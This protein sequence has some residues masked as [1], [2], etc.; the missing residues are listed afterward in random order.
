[1]LRKTL[2]MTALVAA[3]AFGP[4]AAGAET[5]ADALVSAYRNSNLLEQ[6]RAALRAADEDVAQA[7]A[8]LR[9]VLQWTASYDYLNSDATGAISQ[10]ASTSLG[11][12]MTLFDFGRNKINVSMKKETVLAT[13][14]GLRSVE[15][16]VLLSAIQ[17]YSD[18]KSASEQVAINQNSARVLNEELKAS[19]DRFE[20][21]E[22][23]KTDVSLAQ[24]QLASARA[25]LAAAQGNLRSA[26]EAYKAAT[27]HYPSNLAAFPKRPS[28]PG[29]LDAAR[30]IALRTHPSIKQLQHT[31][32]VYDLGVDYARANRLPKITGSLGL[33]QQEQGVQTQSAG[34]ELNQT[35]YS[36]GALLSAQ[37]QAVANDQSA[38]AQ[39]SQA[40]VTVSQNVANAWAAIDIAKAQISAYDQQITAAR[41]AYQGVKEEALLGARTTLDVLSAEQDLLDAQAGRID[42][43][44]TLQVA[45]YQLLSAMG[46]LTVENLKLGIPTYDPAAYYNSVRTAPLTLSPQGKRLDRVLKA[47]GQ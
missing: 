10:S 42:A 46:L 23:T 9:P 40:G 5:L 15:Q 11:A 18:V 41:T 25:S 7:V 43:A 24:A 21:G 39:L 13:R 31:V 28:L 33:R 3:T 37:R 6:N 16:N 2:T 8:N 4:V 47:I 34:I 44:A 12:S 1:M 26:R 45:Y 22:V 19:N 30:D 29:S 32:A 14:E 38:R 20:V 36:G 35:L 27:G 17:A